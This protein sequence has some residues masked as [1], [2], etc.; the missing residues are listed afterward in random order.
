MKET[1]GSCV[2]I[3]VMREIEIGSERR[4]REKREERVPIEWCLP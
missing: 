4:E 1:L 3:G 2:M